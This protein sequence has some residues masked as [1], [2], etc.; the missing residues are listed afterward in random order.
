MTANLLNKTPNYCYRQLKQILIVEDDNI[1]RML[2]RDYLKHYGYYVTS[3]SSGQNFIVNLHQLKPDLILLDLKL[4]DAD[5][6]HL[7]Q[8]I[9]QEPGLSKIPVIVVS[10]FAFK[11]DRERALNLGAR[12]YLVKPINLN[13]LATKVEQELVCNHI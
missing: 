5:G 12:H 11:V 3:L 2:L 10:A 1:N 4:P 9:Q 13:V 7:L 6:Y 8:Q